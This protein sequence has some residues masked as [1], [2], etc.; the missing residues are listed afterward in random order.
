MLKHVKYVVRISI[1][2]TRVKSFF[3]VSFDFFAF[4]IGNFFP[5]P[6]KR[7]MYAEVKLCKCFFFH[8]R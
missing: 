5:I 8:T 7:G 3:W 2:I 6:Q 4:S 1:P